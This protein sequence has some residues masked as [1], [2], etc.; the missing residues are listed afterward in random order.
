MTKNWMK[1]TILVAGATGN[2]GERIVKSLILQGAEVNTIVRS[3]T[4]IAKIEKLKAIGA[5]VLTLQHWNKE[6][7]TKACA[8]A[9]CVVSA[10]A[11]LRNVIIDAQTILLD[12]AVA[13]GVPRF[14]PPDYSLDFTKFTHGENRNLETRREFHAYLKNAPIKA[15]SIFNGA[16]MDML[17]GQ[18][19]WKQL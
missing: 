4:G 1:K 8:G 16:F 2:L 5:I 15:T 11:G 19:P 7:L 14:I 6:E 10:L 9:A 18:M 17:T 3:D 13:A 12:A